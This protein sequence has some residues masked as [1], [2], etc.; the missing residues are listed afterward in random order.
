MS[1]QL[2]FVSG[3]GVRQTKCAV[4]FEIFR[5]LLWA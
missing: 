5:R 2:L 3:M 1:S 4:Q